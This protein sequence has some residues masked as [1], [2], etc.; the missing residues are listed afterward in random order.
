MFQRRG[1]LAQEQDRTAEIT[2]GDEHLREHPPRRSPDRGLARI[3][4]M[5]VVPGQFLEPS[6]CRRR[7]EPSVPGQGLPRS[8]PDLDAARREGVPSG[9][10]CRRTRPILAPDSAAADAADAIARSSAA[11]AGQHVVGHV[12]RL[13]C[14]SPVD[15]EG[16]RQRVDGAQRPRS[17]SM[18]RR[19]SDRN[20][21]A[22]S[23]SLSIQN[24]LAAS[25]EASTRSCSIPPAR[26]GRP[27]SRHPR[28]HLACGLA[29]TGNAR[30][31]AGRADPMTSPAA[32]RNSCSP[33]ARSPSRIASHAAAEDVGHFGGFVAVDGERGQPEPVADVRRVLRRQLLDQLLVRSRRAAS[34]PIDLRR[35]SV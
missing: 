21:T 18:R 5:H 16:R 2:L 31:R 19:M 10:P 24:W 6:R 32:P 33:S 12:D 13:G 4:R 15:R 25:R 20:A 28:F 30:R 34:R 7:A 17:P 22:C 26:R 9:S 14:P 1:G 11:G 27:A 3:R 29:T 8:A 23:D 35:P